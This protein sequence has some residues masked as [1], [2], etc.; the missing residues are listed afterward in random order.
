M[1]AIRLRLSSGISLG[2]T[3][4]AKLVKWSESQNVILL[5]VA[6]VVNPLV[7]HEDLLRWE[8]FWDCVK[9]SVAVIGMINRTYQRNI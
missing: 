2:V 5:S 1:E 7:D 3:N 9:L 6:C 8:H 4:T